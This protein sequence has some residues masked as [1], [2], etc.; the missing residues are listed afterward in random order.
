MKTALTGNTVPSVR[1]SELNPIVTSAVGSESRTIVK[2]AV[3]PDS[4]VFP[5]ISETVTP[6]TSS[7]SFTTATSATALPEYLRS[8]LAAAPVTIL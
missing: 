2:V 5:L 6:A 1:S 7:S 8:A 3:V 4:V